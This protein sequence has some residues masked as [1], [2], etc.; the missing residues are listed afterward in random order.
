MFSPRRLGAKTHISSFAQQNKHRREEK[1]IAPYSVIDEMLCQN[2]ALRSF[3]VKLLITL[4]DLK[5]G[6]ARV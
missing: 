1:N 4:L 2:I 6:V 5:A 3:S